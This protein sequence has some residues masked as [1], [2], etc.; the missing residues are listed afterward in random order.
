MKLP[1]Y[2]NYAP[3]TYFI[4]SDK[5]YYIELGQEKARLTVK[6][7][8]SFVTIDMGFSSSNYKT[9]QELGLTLEPILKNGLA[10][11]LNDLAMLHECELDMFV[12]GALVNSQ[13]FSNWKAK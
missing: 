9:Y 11:E 12:H 5:D 1:F 6:V 7:V 2:D 13:L 3:E 4:E 10:R 8:G